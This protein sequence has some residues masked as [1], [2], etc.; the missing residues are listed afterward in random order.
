[1]GKTVLNSSRNHNTFHGLLGKLGSTVNQSLLTTSDVCFR[2]VECTGNLVVEGSAEI[3]GA[4][5]YV[6]SEVF[7]IKDNMVELN[8]TNEPMR[9]GGISINRGEG[10]LPYQLLYDDRDGELK[11]GLADTLKVIA[12]REVDPIDGGIAIWNNTSKRFETVSA[13]D[14]PMTFQFPLRLPNGVSLYGDSTQIRSNMGRDVIFDSDRRIIFRPSSTVQ[15]QSAVCFGQDESTYIESTLAGTMD[16]HATRV[17]IPQQSILTLGQSTNLQEVTEVGRRILQTSADLIRVTASEL[18]LGTTALKFGTN[19]EIDVRNTAGGLSIGSATPVSINSPMLNVRNISVGA[20]SSLVSSL[21]DDLTINTSG[22]LT[23]NPNLSV[24]LPTGKRMTFGDRNRYIRGDLFGDLAMNSPKAIKVSAADGIILQSGTPLYLGPAS[25]ISDN[26]GTLKMASAGPV[27]IDAEE[28]V[29]RQI[30]V[31]SG[32]IGTSALGMTLAN[33]SE[34]PIKSINLLAPLRATQGIRLEPSAT[35]VHLAASPD[36]GVTLQSATELRL[37]AQDGVI[38]DGPLTWTNGS[39]ISS[40]SENGIANISISTPGTLKANCSQLEVSKLVADEFV[41]NG[42]I[43]Q[44]DASASRLLADSVEAEV[45]RMRE[46]GRIS[47]TSSLTIAVDSLVFEASDKE[48]LRIEDGSISAMSAEM[49]IKSISAA[50]AHLDDITTKAFSLP[51]C[52]EASEETLLVT[53]PA[54]LRDG[55]LVSSGPSQPILDAGPLST[56]IHNSLNVKGDTQAEFVHI[57]QDAV[58]GGGLTVGGMIN[59]G[60]NRMIN[61]ALPT[62]PNDAV[63]KRFLES[64]AFGFRVLAGVFVCSSSNVTLSAPPASIDGYSVTSEGTRVLLKGQTNAKENGVYVLRSGVLARADDMLPASDAAGSLVFVESGDANGGQGFV[65]ISGNARKSVI[66]DSDYMSFTSFTSVTRLA[67]VGCIDIQSNE[68]TLKTSEAFTLDS[69]GHLDIAET[70]VGDTLTGGNGIPLNVAPSQTQVTALGVITEGKWRAERHEVEYG[71]TGNSEFIDGALLAGRGTGPVQSTSD[72]VFRQQQGKVSAGLGI[73]IEPFAAPLAD[74]HVR[75]THPTLLLDGESPTMILDEGIGRHSISAS[76]NALLLTGASEVRLNVGED[77]LLRAS[78]AEGVVIPGNVEIGQTLTV[79]SL[80]AGTCTVAGTTQDVNQDGIYTLSAAGGVILDTD[81]D[82]RLSTNQAIHLGAS[83]TLEDN[84]I[85]SSELS[86]LGPQQVLR[87]GAGDTFISGNLNIGATEETSL[88]IRQDGADQSIIFER[89]EDG[90]S[91]IT[92]SDLDITCR[93][94]S[95]RLTDSVG[96]STVTMTVQDGDKLLVQGGEVDVNG[97][98]YIRDVL[99]ATPGSLEVKAPATFVEKVTFDKEIELGGGTRG[100]IGGFSKAGWYHLG[101][102]SAP[103]PFDATV[104]GAWTCSL[105]VNPMA[106]DIFSFVRHSR[107]NTGA[108]RIYKQGSIYHAYFLMSGAWSVSLKVDRSP[109]SVLTGRFEGVGP[110]PD[111]NFSGFSPSWQ[112]VF[113]SATQV[114]TG[115]SEFSG[116]VAGVAE[117]AQSLKVGDDVFRVTQDSIICSASEMT[118]TQKDTGASMALAANG[119]HLNGTDLLFGETRISSGVSDRD[120]ALSAP[121]SIRLQTDTNGLSIEGDRVEIERNLAVSKDLIVEGNVHSGQ[122]STLQVSLGDTVTLVVDDAGALAV[123]ARITAVGEAQDASDVP[124]KAYVDRGILG[125]PAPLPVRVCGHLVDPDVETPYM[126]DDVLLQEGDLILDVKRGKVYRITSFHRP[127][128][129]LPD[130]RRYVYV[131]EGTIQAGTGWLDSAGDGKFSLFHGPFQARAGNGLSQVGNSLEVKLSSDMRVNSQN[132]IQLSSRALGVGLTGGDGHPIA[133]TSIAHLSEVGTI[134]SGKFEGDVIGVGSGGTGSSG[135]GKNEVIFSDGERQRGGPLYFDPV[136]CHLAINSNTTESDESG[137]GAVG[138]TL[139]DRNI[140]LRGL[141]GSH[142]MFTSGLFASQRSF[143]ISATKAAFEIFTGGPPTLATMVPIFSLRPTGDMHLSGTINANGLQIGSKL[144]TSEGI[145]ETEGPLI[146]RLIGSNGSETHWYGTSDSTN[147]VQDANLLRAGYVGN[148]RFAVQTHHTGT[149]QPGSLTLQAGDNDDQIILM[150]DGSIEINGSMVMNGDMSLVGDVVV[151]GRMD[152]TDFHAGGVSVDQELTIGGLRMTGAGGQLLLA[153]S[154]PAPGTSTSL[155]LGQSSTLNSF[156]LDAGLGRSGDLQ[157]AYDEDANGFG[158]DTHNGG[159]NLILAAHASKN[160]S[161]TSQGELS[162]TCETTMTGSLNVSSEASFAGS[163]TMT[164]ILVNGNLS[165][166]G[167]VGLRAVNG[168]L[169]MDV[170]TNKLM[171]SGDGGLTNVVLG[172]NTAD[173]LGVFG[174]STYH[175]V[176]LGINDE[177]LF[178]VNATGRSVASKGLDISQGGL[179]VNGP[180]EIRGDMKLVGKVSGGLEINNGPFVVTGSDG[181]AR[182][183]CDSTQLISNV[184]VAISPSVQDVKAFAVGNTFLVDTQNGTVDLMG[185]SIINGVD[186]TTPT[187]LCTKRYVDDLVQGFVVKAAVRVA[188]SGSV[189]LTVQISAPSFGGVLLSA[190]DRML[191]WRQQNAVENGIYVLTAQGYAARASDLPIGSTA[192]KVNVYVMEGAYSGKSLTCIS[193]SAAAIVNTH[194]LTFTFSGTTSG[195]AGSTPGVGLQI[196]SDNTLQVALAARSGLS[197]VGGKLSVS[198]DI[199][200]SNVVWEDGKLSVPELVREGVALSFS[201]G[202][203]GALG[204][205]ESGVVYSDGVKLVN[206]A[207]KFRFDSL[208]GAVVIANGNWAAG[209]KLTVGGDVSIN[210]VGKYVYFAD[211]TQT[212]YRWRMGANAQKEFCISY[213]ASNS[214]VGMSDC[215]R[216]SPDG[217]I[218]FYKP[219]SFGVTIPISEGGTGSGSFAPSAVVAS[220]SDGKRLQSVLQDVKGSVIIGDGAGGIRVSSGADLRRE[221]GLALGADVQPWSDVLSTVASSQPAPNAFLVGTDAGGFKAIGGSGARDALGTKK[222]AIKDTVDNADWTAGGTPLATANGGTGASDFPANSIVFA[223]S[224]KKLKGVP[225]L[226]FRPDKNAVIIGTKK[227]LPNNAGL[228]V[229]DGKDVRI[230]GGA[231][232]LDDANSMSTWRVG[233]SPHRDAVTITGPTNV[234]VA[235]FSEEDVWLN[236]LRV[237]GP[238]VLG[239]VQCA[240][241]GVFGGNILVSGHINSQSEIRLLDKGTQSTTFR[242]RKD[243]TDAGGTILES[244]RLNLDTGQATISGDL[245]ARTLKLTQP[246]TTPP[247][248]VQAIGSNVASARIIRARLVDIGVSTLYVTVEAIV[249]PNTADLT[250]PCVVDLDLSYRD[251]SVFSSDGSDLTC[252]MSGEHV[253]GF[254]KA[255]EDT[256]VVRMSWTDDGELNSPDGQTGVRRINLMV[257]H[258]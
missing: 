226:L 167:N 24:S 247:I 39:S 103:G 207:S 144:R 42:V 44:G 79:E 80:T 31:G 193:P 8:E 59:A 135:F 149:S 14:K 67:G 27:I 211:Q 253:R 99:D 251:L 134:T 96:Q 216:I 125:L 227:T 182:L 243:T 147:G 65:V 218:T 50:E 18:R 30:V 185:S 117:V 66:V 238:C 17:R 179:L 203:T 56:T 150:P 72:L 230:S 152:V 129:P 159:H 158:I 215:L 102:F 241:D 40:G 161:L 233:P 106:L 76:G 90:P 257:S 204:F 192:S 71:G 28:L 132:Q 160:V 234:A 115:I 112:V 133:V 47:A 239:E 12:T 88:R 70:A 48:T 186:P 174:N 198:P 172:V 38:V 237:E 190:G 68:V 86:L 210:G 104:S 221:L 187:A 123:G 126:M 4:L 255:I 62:Q 3:R 214:K 9:L 2:N 109:F 162:I 120:L 130:A 154:N 111:G 58:I 23:L 197:I 118:F 75:S 95:L 244:A 81:G 196:A 19:D 208:T 146:E 143:A 176:G 180:T 77:T 116:V 178:S 250:Q 89:S 139:H 128:V 16:L 131:R 148:G 136:K 168:A 254:C 93:G 85:S 26:G 84:R 49:A 73:G 138:L 169:R 201:K 78:E 141:E 246:Y 165:F 51:G 137:E 258:D 245:I 110:E 1:M 105:R 212:A 153:Q 177:V 231:I 209:D 74:L 34:D 98:F 119:L 202:G 53:R 55:L 64:V 249:D 173:V 242:I 155:T 32:R 222:L 92:Y 145:V 171:L 97:A 170:P 54:L 151:D 219:I 20:R 220:S 252:M 83:V 41:T 163:T 229:H 52:I 114:S 69:T 224:D 240:A 140:L 10:R 35:T 100:L 91:G 13:V 107:D 206:D 46:N 6:E 235:A 36:H 166:A 33:T 181:G 124:T 200:G 22:T 121:D 194:P 29:S 5:T 225:A 232:M 61:L 175:Q 63:T 256:R 157:I 11:A 191:L 82:I 37:L 248:D 15:F 7:K 25:S 213:G 217:F 184:P 228:V 195:G 87:L 113:D 236:G 101:S 188:A 156:I 94:G 127:L 60:G 122:I 205:A 43:I 189:D 199:A 57:H 142:V 183:R 21:D 164:D 223:G 108:L 45:L